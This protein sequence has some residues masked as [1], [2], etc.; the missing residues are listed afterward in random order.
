MSRLMNARRCALLGVA[1]LLSIGINVSGAFADLAGAHFAGTPFVE[2]Q[3]AEAHAA[4][5]HHE[6]DVIVQAQANNTAQ[7]N[8]VGTAANAPTFIDI[9]VPIITASAV[10]IT[11]NSEVTFSWP[12]SLSG[13]EFE[14]Q[15]FTIQFPKQFRV[16]AT[17]FNA[18]HDSSG[19]TVGDC[20]SDRRTNLVT[21]TFDDSLA[22]HNN[23][24]GT[25]TTEVKA[26]SSYDSMD[27]D[28]N[29]NGTDRSITLP[30]DGP[31][32]IVKAAPTLP[33]HIT[34]EGQQI[35]GTLIRWVV[36]AP[37]ALLHDKLGER[38]LRFDS[39][40]SG[41]RNAVGHVY[42][43][44]DADEL[45]EYTAEQQDD[46]FSVPDEQHHAASITQGIKDGG[47][48]QSI[49]AEPPLGGWKS[50]HYYLVVF[51]STTA[52][53]QPVASPIHLTSYGVAQD[54]M[55][56]IVTETVFQPDVPAAAES[57]DSLLRFSTPI[58]PTAPAIPAAPAV[59][60]VSP[61][62]TASET[63]SLKDVG[64]FVFLPLALLFLGIIVCALVRVL[65]KDH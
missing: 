9:D 65:S 35:N 33:A 58:T 54:I 61:I 36:S 52:D 7:V 55:D 34:V 56:S 17:F 1:L 50:D 57:Q 45:I 23:A 64:A 48:A 62:R 39:R 49:V 32:G 59:D 21:C 29:I 63:Q 14:G 8:H 24:I 41:P 53:A 28:F 26:L 30:G 4:T 13:G 6:S 2:M 20:T 3:L 27:I 43:N 60:R 25:L 40:L 11:E 31:S 10:P 44:S 37:G 42:I 22:G 15:Q 51:Y 5:S 19:R 38:S 12:W 46:P 47:L 16:P 18:L